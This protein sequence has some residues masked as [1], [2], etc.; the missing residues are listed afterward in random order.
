MALSLE[1]LT[2]PA[3]F[4]EAR[5]VILDV[6]EALG[7][8]T[9][10]WKGGAVVRTIISGVAVMLSGASQLQSAIGRGGFRL[11][12]VEDWL[13]NV[14]A[15]VFGTS[16]DL[17][18]FAQ[19]E[20]TLVNAGVGVFSWDPDEL[21]LVNSSTGK[22]YRNVDAVALG[23]SSTVTADFR[24]A[25]AGSASSALVGEIDAL[26]IPQTGVTC[27]N[28]E[29]LVALDDEEDQSLKIRA[30][31][32]LGA[33]SPLGPWDAYNYIC[34]GAKRDDGT[35]IGVDQVRTTH[36]GKGNIVVY[37]TTPSGSLAG[38]AVPYAGDLGDVQKAIDTY[39]EPLGITA[40]ATNASE[41]AVNVTAE[42]WAYNTANLTDAQWVTLIENALTDLIRRKP[43]GGDVISGGGGGKVWW[44]DI[45]GTI[46]AVRP[47]VFR[48]ALTVPASDVAVTPGQRPVIGAVSITIHQVL[49]GRDA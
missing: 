4:Q 43:M 33:R 42:V 14:A 16:R 9:S 1:E 3:T 26:A 2:D 13:T 20:V 48:V 21:E 5:G 27:S 45:Q 25:E 39:A 12:A 19:G 38:T 6:V 17:E 18:T 24:A 44:S 46:K 37:V 23:A 7:I 29:A 10:N 41:L 49:P 11:T 32:S 35:R 15:D 40:T 36:D 31:E 28:A 34:K 22:T 47:E 30:G 8:P